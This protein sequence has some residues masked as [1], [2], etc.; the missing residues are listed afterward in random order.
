MAT[1]PLAARVE[2]SRAR[3]GESSRRDC[4][5]APP[6]PARVFALQ[7]G[8]GNQ[9]VSRLLRSR[10]LAR[11]FDPYMATKPVKIVDDAGKEQTVEKA[12]ACDVDL[13]RSRRVDNRLEFRVRLE[14]GAEGWIHDADYRS[15]KLVAKKKAAEAK[16]TSPAPE[17]EEKAEVAMGSG[18]VP[19]LDAAPALPLVTP[20]ALGPEVNVTPALRRRYQQ[21]LR[22]M[23]VWLEEREGQLLAENLHVHVRVMELGAE[24]ILSERITYGA[25]DAANQGVIVLKGGHYVVVVPAEDDEPDYLDDTGHGWV[26]SVVTRDDGSCLAD[27]LHIVAAGDNATDEQILGYRDALAA[28]EDEDLDTLLESLVLDLLNGRPVRGLGPAVRTYLLGEAGFIAMGRELKEK[29]E[30]AQRAQDEEAEATGEPAD[31]QD[32]EDVDEQEATEQELAA[33]ATAPKEAETRQGG[34]RH[35]ASGD[36]VVARTEYHAGEMRHGSGQGSD[37]LGRGEVTASALQG[38]EGTYGNKH[39][40]APHHGTESN[41]WKL[42]DI[43]NRPRGRLSI[44][45]EAYQQSLPRWQRI[46]LQPG[47]GQQGGWLLYVPED[48][49][50]LEY[51]ADILIQSFANVVGSGRYHLVYPRDLKPAPADPALAEQSQKTATTAKKPSKKDKFQKKL[52]NRSKR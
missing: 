50:L 34:P 44:D 15:M 30:A 10:R 17:K 52:Q 43:F 26:D 46:K 48:D 16:E 3:A 36:V 27:A 19:A 20:G 51:D 25:A 33:V 23:E 37:W 38:I 28:L 42:K 29:R 31:E 8:A 14:G 35:L 1:S 49:S 9:A 11:A 47:N 24:S 18:N 7:R 4:A 40:L 39:F 2:R 32:E 5:P 13:D 6:L 45:A 22:R 12:A 21:D 41:Y